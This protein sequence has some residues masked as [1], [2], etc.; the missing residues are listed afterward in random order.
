MSEPRFTPGVKPSPREGVYDLWVR[1]NLGPNHVTG[2]S[3]QID[4]EGLIALLSIIEAV[5]REESE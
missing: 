1:E 5:L 2:G 4:R 3:V